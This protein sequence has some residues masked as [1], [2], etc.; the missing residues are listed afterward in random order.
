MKSIREK[1]RYG[2]EYYW[3]KKKKDGEKNINKNRQRTK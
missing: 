3:K 1:R 2:R